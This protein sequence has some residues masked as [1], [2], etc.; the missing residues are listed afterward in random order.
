MYKRQDYD[1]ALAYSNK[2]LEQTPEAYYYIERGQL[3]IESGQWQKAEADF[4]KAAQLDPDNAYAYYNWGCSCKYS[5]RYEEA[6]RL[7]EKAVSLRTPKESLVFFRGL[8]DCYER[9]R[10]FDKAAAAYEQNKA[11]FPE[12]ASV[13]WD[14]AELYCKIGTE[15]MLDRA[16]RETEDILKLKNIRRAY[17]LVKL[18]GIYRLKEAYGK[19]EEI[20][21][22]ALQEEPGYS[23]ACMELAE[24]YLEN[25]KNSRKA[26]KTMKNAIAS[27]RESDALYAD[28]LR[29]MTQILGTRGSWKAARSYGDKVIGIWEK[30]YGSLRAYLG[31]KKYRNARLYLLGK[32]YYFSGRLTEASDCFRAMTPCLKGPE[33]GGKEPAGGESGMCRHCSSRDC[34]EY[35]AGQGLLAEA[36]GDYAAACT[37]YR[38]A[39]EIDGS[40]SATR[41][42]FEAC[43]EEA[44]AKNRQPGFFLKKKVFGGKDNEH[45]NRN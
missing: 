18:A 33:D 34:W 43:R 41:S 14:L 40:D 26:L 3:F 10:R 37:Y 7:L 8:G 44:E 36:A 16:V 27:L 21:E 38:T 23:R 12:N 1:K 9:M 35:Y 4:E 29:V 31:M 20:C 24:L 13:R 32:I 5:G 15:E 28:C 6:A 30:E 45:D 19:A 25:M 2:Q 42:R 22:K 17:Y 39:L 11:E